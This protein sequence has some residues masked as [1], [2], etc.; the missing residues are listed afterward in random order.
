MASTGSTSDWRMR[1]MPAGAILKHEL[2]GLLASWLVRLWFAATVLLTLLILAGNWA[3]MQTAPMLQALLFPYLVFPW[4]LVVMLLGL[5]PVTGSRLESLADGILSRPVTRYEYL[6]AAWAARVVA[7]LGVYLVVMVPV[8]LL[9]VFARREVA[10]DQVT[11]Y[12]V[13]ATLGVV[14]LIQTF[15]VTLGFLVG[16]LLRRPMLAAVVLVFTWLPINLVLSTFSL[17]QFSPLTM[18]QA[19]PSLLRTPWTEVEEAD[20]AVSTK[21]DAE[22][23]EAQAEQFMRLLSG[24][25]PGP[26]RSQP[27]GFFEPRVFENLSVSRLLAGYGLPALGA[28]VL[29]LWVFNRR[30]L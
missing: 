30:D 4:F 19:V 9:A 10:A 21:E 16:T 13:I 7:V 15:L 23:L 28:L 8:A 17:E 18:Y 5:S 24:H 22:A 29:S 1:W 11:V 26:A 27:S 20:V 3:A 14:G 25:S 2:G 6:L 12:G